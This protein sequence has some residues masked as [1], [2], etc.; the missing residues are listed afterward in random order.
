MGAWIAQLTAMGA[1][2]AASASAAAA[3][4]APSAAA[5]LQQGPATNFNNCHFMHSM[6]SSLKPVDATVPAA[7]PGKQPETAA[8]SSSQTPAE[9]HTASGVAA[10]GEGD[11]A[12]RKAMSIT[13]E[14]AED[15]QS[16][17]AEKGK[18]GAAP[19]APGPG[20]KKAKQATKLR[21]LNAEPMPR[22]HFKPSTANLS[23]W[24]NPQGRSIARRAEITD[25]LTTKAPAAGLQLGKTL[26]KEQRRV[27]SSQR[28]KA[29][30]V[31]A[32]KAQPEPAFDYTRALAA[33][34]SRSTANLAQLH[35]T[36]MHKEDDAPDLEPC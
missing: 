1:A 8:W 14:A 18:T 22:V 17:A 11:A 29:P 13:H 6:P 32:E 10:Q 2:M 28:R 16:D 20:S 3:A 23:S 31:E 7:D 34:D 24:S 5:N 9:T 26:G 30:D 35:S 12:A 15:K 33:L 21:H 19:G 25:A 4:G 27:K 36:G